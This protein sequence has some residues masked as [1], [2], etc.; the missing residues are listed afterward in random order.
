MFI[1]VKNKTIM[2]NLTLIAFIFFTTTI[3][4]AQNPDELKAEVVK[5]KDQIKHYEK[6]LNQYVVID[7][8]DTI[9]QVKPFDS[10]YT[11]KF[12]SSKGNRANQSVALVFLVSHSKTNQIMNL[13][14]GKG[15]GTV[16]YDDLGNEYSIINKKPPS[17][18]TVPFDTSVKIELTVEGVMPGTA[19]FTTLL[20]RTTTNNVGAYSSGNYTLTEIRNIPIEW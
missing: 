8:L 15:R 20:I 14:L 4:I 3:S 9:V 10:D 7:S 19:S 18:Y 1:F 11:I 12:I 5:L 16:I 13:D 17:S 6:K 2:K